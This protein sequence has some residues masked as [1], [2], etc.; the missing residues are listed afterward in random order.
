MYAKSLVLASAL[1]MATSVA[2]N[3]PE[4]PRIYFPRD[5]KR[6]YINTTITTSES[7]SS[8]GNPTTTTTT[9]TTTITTSESSSSTGEPTTTTT[10]TTS[11]SSSS[12]GPPTTT[13]SS[14]TT[15]RDLLGDLASGI[16]GSDSTESKTAS[17][18]ITSGSGLPQITI[19]PTTRDTES[20]QLPSSRTKN[21]STDSVILIGP[22]GIVP[23]SKEPPTAKDPTSEASTARPSSVDAP[24]A[25]NNTAPATT[26]TTGGGILDPIGT[27]AT[28][29]LPGPSS[30]TV[31][32]TM[33]TTAPVPSTGASATGG[34]SGSTTANSTTGSSAAKTPSG[35][36]PTLPLPLPL[37]LSTGGSTTTNS[38]VGPTT[39]KTPS[40]F[41]SS[42]TP[43]LTTPSLTL[44]LPTGGSSTKISPSSLLPSNGTTVVPL[45]ETTSGSTI[46]TGLPTSTTRV[47]PIAD[48][49]TTTG[50]VTTPTKV[51]DLPVTSGNTVT[52]PTT[53]QT[54]L[55]STLA[56]VGNSTLTVSHTT[57][58]STSAKPT[59]IPI[60]STSTASQSTVQT[61]TTKP[62]VTSI[63]PTATV[64]NTDNWLPTTIVIEP[65]KFSFTAPTTTATRTTSQ[66]L[67][68]TIPKIIYP[69]DPNKPAPEGTVPIHI[70]FKSPLNY[71]FVSS[72]TVAA[73]QIFKFLPRALSDAS[74][75]DVN[76]LQI[77]KL[78]PYNTQDTWG[79][80]ATIA[81]LNYPATL[82]DKL[83]TDIYSTNSVFYHNTDPIV[84]NLTD[85][86]E[87][88]IRIRGNL[89]DGSSN[90]SG[91]S[92]GGGNGNNN[93]ND[94]FGSG[95]GGNQ[96]S[97]Q[98][99]TTAGI[100]IAALGFS[101]MY[102]AAM[103]IIARRYK[104]KRQ[105]H[106][107]A[108]SIT[109]SPASSE[110]RYNG[111]GSPALMG[112][113]LYSRDVSTYG[114]AGAR[115]SHGSGGHSARTANISAP[116][117][118]ENSLGWN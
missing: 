104:R 111:N 82:V 15:K 16:F 68:T 97:K 57:T 88:Q 116:V 10:I 75:V 41:L 5:I 55:P 109:S 18:T 46:A 84:R 50:F 44:L 64:S 28:L 13:R 98:K 115:D 34:P 36:L 95:N 86:I 83:Q 9:T 30:T 26:S 52:T 112:G 113:A 118:T 8:T 66:A 107:R 14:S 31:I 43:S 67:P 21:L 38:R 56:R 6:E 29:L 51:T 22:T 45:T 78:V 42:S 11:E 77:C 19:Y 96:S 80:V 92:N 48:G 27:L 94:A 12:T 102:G 1:A 20:K 81:E 103:F 60:T 59:V 3:Q 76:K 89:N 85:L 79:F 58:K 17:S 114:A 87:M 32:Q 62:I 72:N 40:G 73:A 108:S 93:S 39:T 49:T 100:A 90:S 117:A 91:E 54:R 101:A 4:R 47:I 25:V 69:D 106:R 105:G 71:L 35:L 33:S 99:A 2:A 63:R 37:P 65:T 110:M 53:S 61:P 7:S 70:G 23:S 74:G 24:P